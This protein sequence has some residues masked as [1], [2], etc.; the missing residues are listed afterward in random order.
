MLVC[1]PVLWKSWNS[2]LCY[3]YGFNSKNRWKINSQWSRGMW[4]YAVPFRW[5]KCICLISWNISVSS[6]NFLSSHIYLAFVLASLAEISLH[7]RKTITRG[8]ERLISPVA[9]SPAVFEVSHVSALPSLLSGTLTP[10]FVTG[11]V[12]SL[13]KATQSR[14]ESS[15]QPLVL[16]VLVLARI[17]L[18]SQAAR[19]GEPSWPGAIPHHMMSCSP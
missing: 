8:P 9:E 18:I 4:R 15:G 11:L 6:Q 2:G 12:C 3:L 16:G 13:S 5:N 17:Q 14:Q 7:R 10:A 19:T 1:D